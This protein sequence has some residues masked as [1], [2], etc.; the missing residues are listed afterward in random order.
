GGGGGKTTLCG[1]G[2]GRP[3]LSYLINRFS[4]IL[5][6]G[7]F[8]FPGL[9]GRGVFSIGYRRRRCVKMYIKEREKL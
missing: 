4:K 7:G 5:A 6:F 9:S 3:R 2:K 8:L 1:L